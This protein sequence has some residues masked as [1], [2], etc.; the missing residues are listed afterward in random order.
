MF[1]EMIKQKDYDEEEYIRDLYRYTSW[2]ITYLADGYKGKEEEL[3]KMRTRAY[4]K[5]YF[6]PG[7]ILRQLGTIRS[8]TD[9]VR[10][11][12]GAKLALG[13]SY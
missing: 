1:D 10:L 7:Y 2:E 11:V 9:V 13:M 6:N 5:F 3:I 8:W 12:S 4:R